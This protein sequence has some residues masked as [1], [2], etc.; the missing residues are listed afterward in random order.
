M[1]KRPKRFVLIIKDMDGLDTHNGFI[2][3]MEL[4]RVELD[5]QQIIRVLAQATIELREDRN[6]QR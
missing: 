4:T 2:G 3:E 5:E 1:A 6:A